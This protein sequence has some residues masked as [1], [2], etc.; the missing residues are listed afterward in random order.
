METLRL[1]FTIVILR[2]R[3]ADA[4]QVGPSDFANWCTRVVLSQQ[5]L[6][7][8]WR[9]NTSLS[10]WLHWTSPHWSRHRVH[11]LQPMRNNV[12]P[13]SDSDA[14]RSYEK[15]STLN[16]QQNQFLIY[17]EEIQTQGF[18]HSKTFFPSQSVLKLLHI[19]GVRLSC[20]LCRVVLRCSTAI[21]IMLHS[22]NSLQPV[23]GKCSRSWWLQFKNFLWSTI[24]LLR[25]IL[26][27]THAWPSDFLDNKWTI[28]H[29]H[30][31]TQ[32]VDWG[33]GVWN[34]RHWYTIAR[35]IVKR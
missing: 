33:S 20:D 13:S 8:T 6:G 34:C 11:D 22:Y 31:K 1:D 25:Y 28:S 12:T 15:L 9:S 32:I 18:F 26:S 27:S 24:E 29:V 19:W 3:I 2:W 10:Q 14:L 17:W 4:V 7:R 30:V 23:A 5:Q 16:F 35:W 21:T